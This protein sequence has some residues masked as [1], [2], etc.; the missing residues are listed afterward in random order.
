MLTRARD[1]SAIGR[2]APRAQIVTMEWGARHM[3]RLGWLVLIVGLIGLVVAGCGGKRERGVIE[4]QRRAVPLSEIVVEYDR[5][6]GVDTWSK[7]TEAQRREFVDTYSKKELI[8]C[9]AA[10]AYGDELTGRD[11]E[12]FDKQRERRMLQR[13]LES[14]KGPATF[15]SQEVD[16][17]MALMKEQ[18]RISDISCLE[19]A[20]AR[21]V[22]RRVLAGEDF[23]AVGRAL[24]QQKPGRVTYNERGWTTRP[25]LP[26]AIGNEVFAL[27]E[28]GE[29]TAPFQTKTFGWLVVKFE[30]ARPYVQNL[31]LVQRESFVRELRQREHMNL[32]AEEVNGKYNFQI[33]SENLPPV[34][35]VFSARFD[36]LSAANPSMMFNDASGAASPPLKSFTQQELALPLV[37]MSGGNWTIEDFVRSL[38]GADPPF[39]PTSGTADQISQQVMNRMLNWAWTKEALQSDVDKDPAFQAEMRREHDRLLL[40]KY[41]ADRLKKYG[42][43]ITDEQM[44]AFFQEHETQYYKPERVSYGFIRFPPDAGT[45]AAQAYGMMQQG[46]VW[47]TV[48]ARAYATDKRVNFQA[49]VSG[50]AAPPYPAIAEAAKKFDTLDDGSP[51]VTP[52]QQID[53]AIVILRVTA[54]VYSE[55]VDYMY[56]KPFVKR[57]L[58]QMAMEDSLVAMLGQFAKRYGLKIN[59]D[60]IR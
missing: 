1:R 32:L 23:A 51:N 25:T 55:P 10:A 9:D 40:D 59:W 42:A 6:N 7:A 16:S 12:R 48:G 38:E 45:L 14:V 11:K 37:R 30:E 34:V 56:A 26:K 58:E 41:Y 27:A 50:N 60:M 33:V 46:A 3:R 17:I 36:S 2:A 29:V 35:R 57:D 31:D 19:E 13:Y 18:R 28:P 4:C 44:S 53:G 47:E 49:A 39:W 52:P 5:L 21:E 22:H 8:L 54:H 43:G 15:T 24:S 20:D